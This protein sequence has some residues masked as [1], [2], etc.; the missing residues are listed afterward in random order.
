MAIINNKKTYLHSFLLN[1]DQ[2]VDHINRD[3]YDCRK[4]NL[5]IVSKS[6]NMMNSKLSTRNKS[7]VKGV[8]YDKSRGLWK[9]YIKKRWKNDKYR[10]V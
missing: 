9:S 7:G 4:S 1:T 5:R 3:I 2:I 6:E 8:Y 10:E